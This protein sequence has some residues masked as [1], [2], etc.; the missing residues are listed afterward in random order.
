MHPQVAEFLLR[1]M[2]KLLLENSKLK[3]ELRAARA[4]ST[5]N[6]AGLNDEG[7]EGGDNEDREDDDDEDCEESDDE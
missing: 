5:G 7:G 1:T 2:Q 4:T 3:E 6:V